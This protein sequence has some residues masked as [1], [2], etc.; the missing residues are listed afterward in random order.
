M[1]QNLY[2]EKAADIGGQRQL[3]KLK[4]GLISLKVQ[5]F[6]IASEFFEGAVPRRRHNGKHPI[7]LHANEAREAPSL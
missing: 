5:I 6:L 1:I 3:K 4:A 7:F 2:E